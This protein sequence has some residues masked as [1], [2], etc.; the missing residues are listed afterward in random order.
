MA[1][2]GQPW[3]LGNDPRAD[4]FFLLRVS[5]NPHNSADAH[6]KLL[7]ATSR[8]RTSDLHTILFSEVSNAWAFQP[9]VSPMTI[10]R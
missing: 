8:A 7:L 5:T 6:L 10:V 9:M 4:S 1:A 3:L 2:F